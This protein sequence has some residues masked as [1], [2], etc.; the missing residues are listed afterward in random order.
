VGKGINT[1]DA[2]KAGAGMP[3]H[4][5]RTG[6]LTDDVVLARYHNAMLM[7]EFCSD[8]EK[9]HHRT[10]ENGNRFFPSGLHD[11]SRGL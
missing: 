7:C 1:T 3:F 8:G 6:E 9:K 10:K 4:P 11:S 2:N 5:G